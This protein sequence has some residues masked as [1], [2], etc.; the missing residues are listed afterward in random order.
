MRDPSASRSKIPPQFAP[1]AL[2]DLD[3]GAQFR[4]LIGE[5]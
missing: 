1:A 5:T 2:E 4:Q 3:A